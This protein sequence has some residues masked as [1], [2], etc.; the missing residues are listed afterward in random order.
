VPL[1]NKIYAASVGPLS[2]GRIFNAI[3]S[4]LNFA[5]NYLKINAQ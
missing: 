4:N 1:L 5:N 2:A 3:K